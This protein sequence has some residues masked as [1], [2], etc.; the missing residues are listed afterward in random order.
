ML[1]IKSNNSVRIIANVY[2]VDIIKHVINS[3]VCKLVKFYEALQDVTN[4]GYIRK[5]RVNM[6]K[7][8]SEPQ[9]MVQ[10][11][12]AN[13]YVAACYRVECVAPGSTLVWD[14]N[15]NNKEDCNETYSFYGCHA[16]AEIK[17]VDELKANGWMKEKYCNT[18]VKTPVY[19][20]YDGTCG[21]VHATTLDK[22][23]T[24]N[25]S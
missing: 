20:W 12:A 1:N 6:K 11:F 21:G 23:E 7:T 18:V 2:E 9:V 19:V 25:A 10:E 4:I 5:R 14:K 15:G 22:C 24:S 3:N 13:E 17:G 16:T 8:W